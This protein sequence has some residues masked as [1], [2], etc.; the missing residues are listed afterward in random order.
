[1]CI[2]DRNCS[3]GKF[4]EGKR[5]YGMALIMAKLQETSETVIIMN[6]VSYTHLHPA[7]PVG[8]WFVEG[9]FRRRQ[10]QHIEA[11]HQVNLDYL[12]EKGEIC[13]LYTS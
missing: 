8:P 2:R 13:L 4:G 7:L 10:P 6:P 9:H 12:V 1:M 5:R 3:E 11:A